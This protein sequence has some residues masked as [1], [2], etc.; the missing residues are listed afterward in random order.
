MAMPASMAFL[1]TNH[2]Q[3]HRWA[4][5]ERC[6]PGQVDGTLTRV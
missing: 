5:A 3:K 4:A 1:Q 2:L 6:I